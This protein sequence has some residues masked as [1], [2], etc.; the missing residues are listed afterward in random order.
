MKDVYQK[1]VGDPRYAEG[2]KF[3]VP[4]QGH[5]EGSVG[6]HLV[7]LEKNLA[8]MANGALLNPGDYYKLVVLIHSHDTMKYAAKHHAAI[9]DPQSHA[10][11]ARKFLS[12]FTDD[13]DLLNI[14]QAHDENLAL[15]LQFKAKGTYSEERFRERVIDKINDI[16]LL[17]LFQLLDGFTPGKTDYRQMLRWFVNQV[18]KYKST[19]RVYHALELFGL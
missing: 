17:L 13:E 2:M 18:N 11:L 7:D 9:T 14:V 8:T 19:P 16:E 12:E 1:I 5:S 10:S 4:R 6:N 15:W 3:G